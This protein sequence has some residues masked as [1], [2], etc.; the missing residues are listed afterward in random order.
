MEYNTAFHLHCEVALNSGRS[1]LLIRLTQWMTYDGLLE[2]TPYPEMNDRLVD[3]LM[4]SGAEQAVNGGAPYLIE[5][6][7]RDYLRQPGDMAD[8]RTLRNRPVE[9]LPLVSSIGVFTSNAVS[10]N[11]ICH[12]LLPFVWFQSEYGPPDEETTVAIRSV[13]WERYA[14]DFE[15]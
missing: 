3:H 5:P 1:I 15:L 8:R 4:K 6:K 7:R 9:W 10:D 12:S 11:P 14:V 2:G 13:D